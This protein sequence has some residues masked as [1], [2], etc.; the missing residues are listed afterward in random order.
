MAKDSPNLTFDLYF[1]FIV[2]LVSL[3]PSFANG[4]SVKRSGRQ[5]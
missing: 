5:R 2:V 3:Y 4:G 1:Q